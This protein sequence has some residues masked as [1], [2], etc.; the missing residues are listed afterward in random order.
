M[1][2]ILVVRQLVVYVRRHMGSAWEML[3]VGRRRVLVVRLAM[4]RLWP[5]VSLAITICALAWAK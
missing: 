4:Y 5:H 1:D 3:F 2:K